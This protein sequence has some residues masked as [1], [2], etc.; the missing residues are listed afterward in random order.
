[1]W[2]LLQGNGAIANINVVDIV[3]CI[4]FRSNLILLLSLSLTCPVIRLSLIS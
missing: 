1:M 2:K 3:S 4:G